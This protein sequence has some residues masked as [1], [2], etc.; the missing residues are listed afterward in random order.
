MSITTMNPIISKISEE[1]GV[2]KFTLSGVNVSIANGL[3]RI[4]LA[5]IPTVVFRTTPHD[6]NRT[7]IEINTTRLN[8][9]ILK[10]RLSCIPIHITDPEFLLENYQVEVD[11]KNESDSIEFVTTADFRVKDLKT[12]LYLPDAANKKIFPPNKITGDYIDFVR[13][14]PRISDT[15]AGEHLKMNCL[16]DIGT[17]QQDNAF[18]VSATCAYAMT[19]DNIKIH[20]TWALKADDLK[21]NKQTPEEIAFA[22]K[23]WEL[24]DAQRL[25]VV[26]SFD[27]IIET[28]GP[29]SNMALMYKSADVMLQKLAKFQNTMQTTPDLIQVSD[30]TIM[31]CFD[32]TIPLEG[33]TLGKVIEY[34]LYTQHFGRILTFCGFRKPHPHIDICK[35]RLAFKEAGTEPAVVLK[36]LIEAA[37][38]ASQIY[39]K[40]GGEFME[41]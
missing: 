16:F 19:P 14:R 8:N 17:A 33:Y 4:I 6:Q 15:I 38:Q 25:F 23:D 41:K 22:K 1:E 12:N 3:R 27:F 18:N 10:Q 32:I 35:I 20:E 30:A 40:I 26:D 5:E 24:L 36:Y 11:K 37:E 7:E 21:K 34:M 31:N 28:V 13:L 29:F 9:E 2:L 39:K